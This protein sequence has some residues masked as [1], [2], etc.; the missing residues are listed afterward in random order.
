MTIINMN[1]LDGQKRIVMTGRDEDIF[2]VAQRLVKSACRDILCYPND[3]DYFKDYPEII[4]ALRHGLED[5]EDTVVITTQSAEFLDCLLQS[6]IDF[7]LATV[8]VDDK[9]VYYL[10]V[11]SKEEAWE[12]RCNFKM[13]LRI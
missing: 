5:D 3:T 4:E 8:R 2:A 11:L 6:D 1:K 10:R 13:E 9:G 7:I 12:N